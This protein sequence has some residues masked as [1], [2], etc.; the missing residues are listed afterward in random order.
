VWYKHSITD[1]GRGT[2]LSKS[3]ELPSHNPSYVK[4]SQAHIEELELCKI[5]TISIDL[6]FSPTKNHVAFKI[7]KYLS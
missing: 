5:V 2:A 1:A 7:Y 6:T 4:K 3:T